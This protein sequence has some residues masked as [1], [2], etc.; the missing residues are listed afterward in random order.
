MDKDILCS[1]VEGLVGDPF[2]IET[3]SAFDSANITFKVNTSNLG[4]TLFENLAILWYD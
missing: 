1:D 4:E 2:S 3:T